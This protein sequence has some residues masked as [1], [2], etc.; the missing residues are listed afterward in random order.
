MS[1]TTQ[2]QAWAKRDMLT[3]TKQYKTGE[4]IITKFIDKHPIIGKILTFIYFKSYGTNEDL[5]ETG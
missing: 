5:D 4:D 1:F 2:F 3:K